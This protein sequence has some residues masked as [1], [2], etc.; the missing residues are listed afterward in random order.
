MQRP[1]GKV[2]TTVR[3]YSGPP[4]EGGEGRSCVDDNFSETSWEN[5]RN[6]FFATMMPQ[7]KEYSTFGLETVVESPR[8]GPANGVSARDGVSAKDGRSTRGRTWSMESEEQPKTRRSSSYS[9]VVIDGPQKKEEDAPPEIAVLVIPVSAQEQEARSRVRSQSHVSIRDTVDIIPSEMSIVDESSDDEKVIFREKKYVTTTAYTIGK[10]ELFDGEGQLAPGELGPGEL[11]PKPKPEE[12]LEALGK[13]LLEESMRNV[14]VERV[15][16]PEEGEVEAKKEAKEEKPLGKYVPRS[17]AHPVPAAKPATQ[18]KDGKAE[19]TDP[20]HVH[21]IGSIPPITGIHYS[22][23]PA[24]NPVENS[25]GETRIMDFD[26]VV[27]DTI[28]YIEGKMFYFPRQVVKLQCAPYVH[29][30]D[31]DF[32]KEG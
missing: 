15:V 23:S 26:F 3:A 20:P 9:Q 32:M 13:R 14:P 31:T 7:E 25:F 29:V 10:F 18:Q 4:S 22:D 28:Q 19:M 17:I 5:Y 24:V 21:R 11:G 2:R 8:F 30:H 1:V 12:S 16:F 6:N 27:N